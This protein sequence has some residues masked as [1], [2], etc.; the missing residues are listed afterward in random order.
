MTDKTKVTE[1]MTGLGMIGGGDFRSTLPTRPPELHHVD[2]D[3][4]QGVV[5]AWSVDEVSSIADAAYAN[6]RYFLEAI[7][8]L[9]GRRPRLVEWVGPRRPPGDE[10]APIDLRIDHV[11]LV[12]CKYM[13]KVI[14]N[15]SPVRLFDRLL[16]AGHGAR[17]SDWYHDV[18]P[19]EHQRLWQSCRTW[20]AD[21][22]LPNDVTELSKTERRSV[23]LALSF[24]SWPVE[25]AADYQALCAAVSERSAVRWNEA[26]AA[27]GPNTAEAI[28]WRLLRIGSAPYFVLGVHG[29]GDALRLRVASPWDWRQGFR[30]RHLEVE[31][32]DGGQPMVRWRAVVQERSTSFD[33]LIDGHVE[34]RWSHRR[35]GGPPE[36]KVYLD[37]PFDDVAGYW[38]LR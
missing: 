12:S 34:I 28:L 29:N 9:R 27:A 16:A 4:W 8:A 5:D 20:L 7:D 22:S 23:A 24:R 18:A 2:D 33:R 30:F 31:P 19:T 17:S 10:V 21:E 14:L 35:F 25:L 13:S 26:I 36:A 15:P 37:T 11:Y 38:P 6:G 1:I 32:L 3:T